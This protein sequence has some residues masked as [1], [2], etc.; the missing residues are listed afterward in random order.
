[1][2]AG[3]ASTASP[4]GAAAAYDRSTLKAKKWHSPCSLERIADTSSAPVPANDDLEELRHAATKW[5]ACDLRE[6]AT[7]TVFGEGDAGSWLMLVGEQPGDLPG[8]TAAQALISR[9]FRVTQQHGEVMPSPLGPPIAA[10]VHPSSI[11]RAPDKAARDAAYR[12]LVEDLRRIAAA[13]AE[14][15]DSAT[16]AG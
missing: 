3:P 14:P 5:R 16:V 10:T 1:M 8:A 6:H 9:D 15:S 12:G 7:Q 4:D 11:L 2:P 13:V